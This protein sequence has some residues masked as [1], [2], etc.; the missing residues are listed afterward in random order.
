MTAEADAAVLAAV[1]VAFTLKAL[2]HL[3]AL[4]TL[5]TPETLM[6]A[7]AANS[8]EFHLVAGVALAYLKAQEAR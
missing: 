6:K 3:R 8:A 2:D 5:P 1:A 4:E 7:L